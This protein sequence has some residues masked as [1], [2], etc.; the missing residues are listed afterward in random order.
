MRPATQNATTTYT[1]DGGP[2]LDN[3]FKKL[4]F[5]IKFQSEQVF[6]SDAVNNDSQILYERD[7]KDRVQKAAPYLTLDSDAYPAV[8]D[9]KVV[10]IVDGY[11]TSDTYPYS[12][13]RQLSRS[14]ADTY[15]P[16]PAFAVDNI[17]YIRNSVKATVDAY[18][19]KVTLYA[20]DD[21]DPILKTWQK[22][23]PNTIEPM[24]KMSSELLSHVRYPA[25][26][27]KV[28]R[29]I[30]G[31]YHVTKADSF[32][33]N[34]DAWVTPNEP[35]HDRERKTL[36]PPYYLT[37]KMPGADKP[38]FSLYSTYIPQNARG[39]PGRLPRRECGC[40]QDSGE[41]LSRLRTSSRCSRCRSRTPC[42]APGRCRTTSTPIRRSPPN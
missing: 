32:Y 12:D 35:G 37:M 25:D 17:N 3:I 22:I 7:P 29:A 15:T 5:A 40:R 1:G 6:L 13:I 11:T 19:G 26:L 18:S 31:T 41:D 33:S 2:K 14:I 23:F 21:Q 38:A 30:L 16:A 36:Q 34:D 28:Q 8:V 4:I 20:W 42:P 39:H 24:S 9:G 27:F 10:W